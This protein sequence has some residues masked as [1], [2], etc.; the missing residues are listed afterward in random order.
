MGWVRDPVW[1]RPGEGLWQAGCEWEGPQT[2]RVAQLGLEAG[3]ER[4]LAS[5]AGKLCLCRTELG[6]D[7][8]R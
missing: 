3:R 6:S 2:Q 7:S 4:E 5:K 1:G 8:W